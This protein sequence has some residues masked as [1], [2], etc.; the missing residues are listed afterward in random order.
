MATKKAHTISDRERTD[1]IHVEENVDFASMYLS[2][3]VLEGL[4]KSGFIRPSPIQLAAIPL[5]R[6]GLDLV[7]QAKSGTGKTCVFTVV[8][9]EMLSVTASTTQ[10]LVIAPTREIAV[11][12]TQV[13]N[14]I[15]IGTPG[16]RAYAFIG[17]IALSQDKAKLSCCHIAVGTPGRLAQLVELG[18]LKLDNVRLLVLD[19]A[20]QLL[21]GQFTK[22]VTSLASALPLNKQI[23]ALS[24]TYTDEVAKVAE[25][26]MRSPNHVRLGR[27]C[28]ALL[29]V[30]QFARLLPFHHQPHRIQQTKMSELLSVL[31]TVTFNQCLV[32]TNSQLRAESICN[33]LRATGW[34][35]SYLTGGQAQRDRLQALDALCSYKCRILI[36]TDLSARGLDSEHVNLVI[37]LDMPRD[38]ATYLHRVGRAGRFGSRGGAI[39]LAT[40]GDDWTAMRAIVTLANV[41][42]Y[43]LQEGWDSNITSKEV[44]GMEEVEMLGEEELNLWLEVSMKKG[45]SRDQ[46][47]MKS[48]QNGNVG[49]RITESVGKRSNSKLEIHDESEKENLKDKSVRKKG[50]KQNKTIVKQESKSDKPDDHGKGDVRNTKETI[51]DDLSC[52]KESNPEEV[53]KKAI[54]K[55]AE[56]LKIVSALLSK[57]SSSFHKFSYAEIYKELSEKHDTESVSSTITIPSLPDRLNPSESELKVLCDHIEDT[58][59]DLENKIASIDTFWKSS[60]VDIKEALQALIEGKDPSLLPHS[61]DCKESCSDLT[62]HIN[63]L[64]PD[65]NGLSPE[66]AVST[67][68]VNGITLTADCAD[69]VTESSLSERESKVNTDSVS[70]LYQSSKSTTQSTSELCSSKKTSN[71]RGNKEKVL[72]SQEIKQTVK[73]SRSH[74][75]QSQEDL[76][77]RREPKSKKVQKKLTKRPTSTS[78]D[79]SFESSSSTDCHYQQSYNGYYDSQQQQR[80]YWSQMHGMYS[81]GYQQYAQTDY[82]SYG[83]AYQNFQPPGG[84]GGAQWSQQQ[85]NY[86]TGYPYEWDYYTMSAYNH[87]RAYIESAQKFASMMDYVQSMGRMS[88]WIARDYHSRNSQNSYKCDKCF[89]K[90][91]NKQS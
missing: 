86:Y 40:E 74:H 69:K 82:P 3:H 19:E 71:S 11:Q 45:F 27:D 39:T 16:L 70:G 44:E 79:T 10:V 22:G 12:I 81:A 61:N 87:K 2:D 26:L 28:P 76:E 65:E 53:A 51:N 63:L 48:I 84:E 17:G 60:K 88:A 41:K 32:F 42:A 20:D 80:D 5:G 46:Q 52:K 59:E 56:N 25:E 4:K 15:G 30:N 13:I 37:N 90:S 62:E 85:Q 49:E 91:T 73:K 77:M 54:E 7:V 78:T 34:P 64:E 66:T 89:K 36:S 1:D 50:H 75:K 68:E 31:S 67:H 24:A 38:Q 18:L 57:V 35:V 55:K 47:V 43:L 58:N 29:G 33:E 8:A 83:G 72:K 6:C 14:S 21:T 23:L 9:L